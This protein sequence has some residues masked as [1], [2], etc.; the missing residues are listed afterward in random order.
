M[1]EDDPV[2]AR[3]RAARREILAECGDD[4]EALFAWAKRI[5]ARYPDRVR[6]YEREPRQRD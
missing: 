2:V 5:E 4:A 1:P 3:V 6:G